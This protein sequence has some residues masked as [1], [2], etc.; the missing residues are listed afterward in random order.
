MRWPLF[1]AD[2]LGVRYGT[3]VRLFTSVII[4]IRSVSK[5]PDA[6]VTPVVTP[7]E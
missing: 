7:E 6:V 5:S 3:A 1:L 2:E 4:A